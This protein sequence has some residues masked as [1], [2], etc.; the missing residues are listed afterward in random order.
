MRE[1]NTF[2]DKHSQM[3]AGESIQR[4]TF[5]E[6]WCRRGAQLES[7]A[8]SLSLSL[9]PLYSLSLSHTHTHTH[10][11]THN[12]S[13]TLS[14]SRSRRGPARRQR[15]EGGAAR[16][17]DLAQAHRCRVARVLRLLRAHRPAYKGASGRRRPAHNGAP[18]GRGRGPAL[19][20]EIGRTA[21]SRFTARARPPPPPPFPVLTGQVSSLPSY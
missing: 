5:C 18:R 9:Q 16:G 2:I 12:H 10:T 7:G 15:R 1:T 17:A 13:L 14:A 6:C 19:R 11:N 21:E 4:M 8:T 3:N 20:G